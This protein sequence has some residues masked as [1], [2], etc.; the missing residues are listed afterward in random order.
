[1]SDRSDLPLDADLTQPARIEFADRGRGGDLVS[2]ASLGSAILRHMRLI[3]WSVVLLV[4]L[5]VTGGIL[6]ANYISE[7]QFAPASASSTLQGLMGVAA[8]LGI[9]S[10]NLGGG[11]SVD[12]YAGLLESRDLMTQAVEHQY[13]IHTGG[14]PE[15]TAVGTLIDLYRVSGRSHDDQVLRAVTKLQGQMSIDVDETA[16]TV[17]LKVK[18]RWPDLSEQI[19]R[20]LID[21]V[22][23]FNVTQAQT[24]AGVERRFVEGRLAAAQVSLD[25]AENSLRDF[26]EQNRSVQNSPRLVFE[27]QRLQARVDLRQGLYTSLAQSYEQARIAEVRD[28]PVITVIDVPEASAERHRHILRN[29][30]LGL[31]VGVVLGI[32]L[33]FMKEYANRD[34]NDSPEEYLEFVRLRAKLW[35]SLRPAR[36]LGRGAKS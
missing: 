1:M 5:L 15:G 36:F 13:S 12:F 11:Q 14:G 10:G 8:Q 35:Q 21:A 29:G 24:Q 2:L 9:T 31:V 3:V 27:Q 34:R 19:N 33:A 32:G 28:T 23:H 18:A 6:S 26:L 25:S 16:N 22:N 7:S 17:T 4:G 30:V 20:V